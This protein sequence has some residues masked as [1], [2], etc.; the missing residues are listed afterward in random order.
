M[1][2]EN[3]FTIRPALE[4]D[5]DEIIVMIRELAIFEKLEDQVQITA[6]LLREAFFP[7][8]PTAFGLVAETDGR[9]AGYAIYYHTFSTFVGR[10]GVYLE[11]VYVRPAF[12]KKGLGRAFIERIA[13]VGVEEHCGRYEWSAL[14]WNKNALSLYASLGAQRMEEWILLRMD[15]EQMHQLA[16]NKNA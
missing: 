4:K 12:R 5:V 16:A 9:L 14:R 3:P 8:R 11:D 2:I 10:A 1:S 13:R 6:A 15:S 7:P